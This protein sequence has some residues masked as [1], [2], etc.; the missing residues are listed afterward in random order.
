MDNLDSLPSAS[1]EEIPEGARILDVREDEEWEAG[2]IDGT[3]AC[4]FAMG[5]PAPI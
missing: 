5:T 3:R 1:V 2:H 4:E